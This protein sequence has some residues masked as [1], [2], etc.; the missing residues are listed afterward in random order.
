[1]RTYMSIDAQVDADFTWA[2]HRSFVRRTA[3][4]LRGDPSA[5]RSLLSFEEVRKALGVPNKVRLGLRVVPVERIVGSVGRHR[6][7]DRTFLPAKAS[8]EE[9]WKRIDR[10]F[11]RGEDLPPVALAKVG[12]AYFVEDGNHRVSVARY[13]GVEW[14]DAEVVEVRGPVPAAWRDAVC[15]MCFDTA[16]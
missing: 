12:G 10:A 14:I 13:Q 6:E 15:P 2:R 7:F 8:L 5:A 3:A 1:M 9:N 11:H 4:R 16:A